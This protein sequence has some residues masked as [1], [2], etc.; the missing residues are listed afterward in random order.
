M[1]ALYELVVFVVH[2]AAI[3]TSM[4]RTGNPNV[5]RILL[6]SESPVITDN[7][8]PKIIIMMLIGNTPRIVAKAVSF[9]VF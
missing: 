4:P 6:I 5:Q 8:Y 1:P 7:I 3:S 2:V 9:L